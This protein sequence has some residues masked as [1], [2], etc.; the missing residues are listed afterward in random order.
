MSPGLTQL[1]RV[2]PTRSEQQPALR[3]RR[4]QRRRHT[5]RF[6]Q[7]SSTSL[8]V[9]FVRRCAT[10]VQ[11]VALHAV[12]RDAIEIAGTHGHMRLGK[13]AGSISG[14]VRRTTN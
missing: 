11:V 14:G 10:D 8:T 12:V 1:R 5:L 7:P 3:S 4:M 9:S 6:Y 13:V 2:A